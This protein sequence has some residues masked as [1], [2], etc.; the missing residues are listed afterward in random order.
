MP[1]AP[2]TVTA[3][4]RTDLVLSILGVWFTIGLMLDAWAHNNVPNLESFFTPWHAVFYSGFAVTAGWVLWTCRPA[5]RDGPGGL[6]LAPIG[7]RST[8]VALGVFAAAAAGDLVWH[9]AF[10]IEQDLAILFSPTHLLLG[11]AMITIV[12]TPVRSQWADP[13]LG[14]S[15]GLRRL[16][17]AVLG[18]AFAT[19]LVMLYLQYAN[20]LTY[21]DWDVV[22][23]TAGADQLHTAH[24]VGSFVVSNVVLFLPLL[25]LARRWRLPAGATTIIYLAVGGLAAA[26]TGLH[27]LPILIAFLIAGLCVDGLAVVLAPGV[28]RPGRYR[29]FAAAAALLTWSLVVVTALLTV[30]RPVLDL[31]VNPERGLEL[32]TGLPIVQALIAWLLAL[33]LTPAPVPDGVRRTS[34]AV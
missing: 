30:E 16:L 5:L 9:T 3:S 13:A 29:A 20:A 17:P 31:G 24:M 7:Y 33:L 22:I 18:M 26:V 8:V 6:R 21:P 19:T 1:S 28:D 25:A 23:S 11:A 34:S 4:Y 12:T 32:W 14:T 10:G 2:E 27:N 15:P